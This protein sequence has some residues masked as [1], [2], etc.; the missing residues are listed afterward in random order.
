MSVVLS[1]VSGEY[2]VAYVRSEEETRPPGDYEPSRDSVLKAE[3][4]LGEN[5]GVKELGL[6]LE[7]EMGE[8]LIWYTKVD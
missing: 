3:F 2:F 6:L 1:H 8:D 7:P 4:R 5:G